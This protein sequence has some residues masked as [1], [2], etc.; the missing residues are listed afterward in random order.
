MSVFSA[1]LISHFIPPREDIIY[2][3]LLIWLGSFSIFFFIF[4]TRII[5]ALYII[6]NK[7]KKSTGWP[8]YIKIINGLCWAGPFGLGAIIPSIH[9][10]LILAGIGLGN[11]STFI[12]FL[13]KNKI[14]NI[15]QLIVGVICLFSILFTFG[16]FYINVIGKSDGEFLARILISIA[17]GIGGLYSAIVKPE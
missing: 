14:K 10:Y 8:T 17:Y 5:K 16:L 15:D 13:L 7:I 2:F 9:E 4:K 3:Y 1:T 6:R 11:V 12:I